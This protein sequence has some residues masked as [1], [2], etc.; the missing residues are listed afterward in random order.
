MPVQVHQLLVADSRAYSFDQY[1]H[2]PFSN[3]SVDF[4]IQRGAKID[5]LVLPTV[6]KLRSYDPL[7]FTVIKLA[8]GIND[9]TEFVY[10]VHSRSKVLKKSDLSL[11][12][13]FARLYRFKQQIQ[14]CRPLTIVSIVTIPLASFS[15]FQAS[16]HLSSPVLSVEELITNQKQLDSLLDQANARIR[17]FNNELQLGMSTRTLSWHTSVRKPSKRKTRT[18]KHNK[19]LRNDFSQLYDGLHAT[20]TL[21]KKWYNELYRSFDLDTRSLLVLLNTPQ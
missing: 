11:D 7:D 20:S 19:S 14:A 10:T 1:T 2:P 15:K 12:G 18:S 3:L 5:D 8:A 16:R 4:V 21:K 6:T 17:E 9:L 13:F